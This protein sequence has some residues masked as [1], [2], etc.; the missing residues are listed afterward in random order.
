MKRTKEFRQII[1]E[2]IEK[3][4]Q[5]IKHENLDTRRYSMLMGK[6]KAYIEVLE[7]LEE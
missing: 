4:K 1:K 5:E 3:L 7:I 2:R 6:I